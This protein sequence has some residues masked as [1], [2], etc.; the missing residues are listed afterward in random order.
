MSD[1]PVGGD[2]AQAFDPSSMRVLII[3]DQEHVRTYVR[4]VLKNAGVT[5]VTEA[6]DGAKALAAVTQPGAWFDLILC[7]LRMPERDGIETIRSFASLGIHSAIAIMSVEEERVI[8]TAGLLAEMQGLRLL[9]S[10]PKP[11]TADKLEALFAK[12]REGESHTAENAVMAPE[13]DLPDAFAREQFRLVYQPKVAMRTG[14]FAGVEALVRWKHPSIGVLHPASFLSLIES[15][16]EYSAL[17]AEFTLAE[18]I[19][20]AGRWREAGRELR[21]AVNLSAR[22][23]D[24]LD[25]PERL[26]AMCAARSV[27]P[28]WITLELAESDVA[29]DDVRL[30]EVATRLRLKGFTLSIDDFGTG[31]SGTAKLQRLPFSELKID[32]QFVDGCSRNAAHRSVVETSLALARSLK[33][34]CVA[35]GVQQRPDWDLLEQLGCDVMQGYFIAR[36]MSE[37]GLEAWAMQWMLRG[38]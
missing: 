36:P 24:R 21:V 12:M 4:T 32:R 1:G 18:A 3:D 19:A 23:L 31:Q 26:T 2:T 37:E 25:L 35:E 30:I 16:A 22:A 14:A 7:D 34:T 20:C 28:G 6:G 10:V 17:L 5:D 15:S 38:T 27:E 13:S 33:M 9:G 29:R 8:E 11:L